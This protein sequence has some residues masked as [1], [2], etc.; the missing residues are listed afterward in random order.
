MKLNILIKTIS[1]YSNYKTTMM[2]IDNNNNT[3][4]EFFFTLNM[5][6]PL[7]VYS[8]QVEPRPE[9]S[10]AREIMKKLVNMEKENINPCGLSP[11]EADEAIASLKR[12]LS[13]RIEELESD[14]SDNIFTEEEMECAS[15]RLDELSNE[16]LKEQEQRNNYDDEFEVFFPIAPD[17]GSFTE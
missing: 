11:E 9:P 15:R 14:D 3:D 4:E 1:V 6:P 5:Q 7:T 12:G 17:T 8:Y 2:Q 13:L 16:Y 10:V